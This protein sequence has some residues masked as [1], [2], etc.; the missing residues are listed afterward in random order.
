MC[1]SHRVLGRIQRDNMKLKK[2]STGVMSDR[3]HLSTPKCNILVLV[4][5]SSRQDKYFCVLTREEACRSVEERV[6]WD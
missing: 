4:S 6:S 2:V 1:L 5:N 3:S